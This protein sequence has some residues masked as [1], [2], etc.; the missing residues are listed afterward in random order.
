[1]FVYLAQLVDIDAS[2]LQTND[3]IGKRNTSECSVQYNNTIIMSL[4]I[5]RAIKLGL[6][7]IAWNKTGLVSTIVG[8]NLILVYPCPQLPTGETR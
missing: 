2:T 7:H 3:L 1:M 4:Y 8:S 5:F 6:L